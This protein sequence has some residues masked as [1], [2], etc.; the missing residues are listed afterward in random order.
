MEEKIQ[1]IIKMVQHTECEI[2]YWDENS[3][4]DNCT[5]NHSDLWQAKHDILCNIIE[6]LEQ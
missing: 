4:D 5:F 6:I 2:N 1:R 3:S